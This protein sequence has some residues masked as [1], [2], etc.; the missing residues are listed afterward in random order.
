MAGNAAIV[1]HAPIST[2]TGNEIAHLFLQAGFPEHLLQHFILDNELAAKVIAH[3]HVVAVTL[4]GSEKAGSIVAANAA[5]HLKKAVLELGGNDPYLVLADADL[6]LAAECIVKSRLNNCG[7]VCIAA[8]RI[9][10]IESVHN[11]LVG[12]IKALLANYK[13]GDP[14]G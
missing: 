1:K 9:I 10:A 4:T 14:L 11:E 5:N 8:K 2:G 3:E 12:K 6:D 13:M 7:Q